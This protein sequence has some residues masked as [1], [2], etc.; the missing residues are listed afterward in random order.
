MEI[1]MNSGYANYF[2]FAFLLLSR[3]ASP[4]ENGVRQLQ[5]VSSLSRRLQMPQ[6]LRWDD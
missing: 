4:E 5:F 2:P 1:I 6:H 3:D